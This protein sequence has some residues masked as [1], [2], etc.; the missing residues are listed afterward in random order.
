[1]RSKTIALFLALG[2]AASVTACA[3]EAPEGGE[4][5]EGTPEIEQTTPEVEGGEGGEGG[6]GG[7]IGGAARR[8]KEVEGW[9]LK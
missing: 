6:D 2:M 4:G 9:K 7:S 3:G 5:G 8:K 1:M